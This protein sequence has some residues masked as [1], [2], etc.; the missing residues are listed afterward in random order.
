MLPFLI[1]SRNADAEDW[2]EA[3]LDEAQMA[4]Y[5]ASEKKRKM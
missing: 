4:I 2:I 1:H 3:N 5:L